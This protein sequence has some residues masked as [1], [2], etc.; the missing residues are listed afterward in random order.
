[1]GAGWSVVVLFVDID[2]EPIE[3]LAPGRIQ[4]HLQD[5]TRS[6]V[7]VE[8]VGL[9][10]ERRTL[11][12]QPEQVLDPTVRHVR[13]LDRPHGIGYVSI[14]A[15][16]R[17]TPQEFDRAVQ[18]LEKDG[19]RSLVIDLRGNPGGI[20]DAAVEVANRFIREGTIVTTEERHERHVSKALPEE[21]KLVGMPLVLLLDGGSASAS[22]VLAG[23]VQ[24]WAV[25]VLV[26][27]SSYGKGTVQ[28][29]TRIGEDRAMVKLTTA[30]YLTP[31]GRR[32][33]R[34][35]TE[36][37]LAPDLFVPSENGERQRV[38]EYLESYS[39]PP[40][41]VAALESWERRE[42]V[43]LFARPPEDR[44]LH[45]ACDLLRGQLPSH[46]DAAE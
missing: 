10:G 18:L 6:T 35:E 29:L 8:V 46:A 12:I 38:H 36:S 11:E 31:S 37:G 40:E 27:E 13:T 16:S 19:L 2:V 20:L 1:L 17:Q 42:R 21:A 9:D 33:E 22:E 23:A 7:E 25:G 28:T 30:H 39:P 44:Q 14:A 5:P 34:R 15:F 45:A 3:E 32:I 26:G 41:S 24:D 4:M 43:E